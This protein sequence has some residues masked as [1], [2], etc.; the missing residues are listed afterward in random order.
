MLLAFDAGHHEQIALPA[1]LALVLDARRP[2]IV[3]QL[4]MDE[5]AGVVFFWRDI[6]KTPFDGD[7]VIAVTLQRPQITDGRAVAMNEAVGDAPRF[8]RVGVVSHA[9]GQAVEI[10][11]VEEFDAVGRR[12]DIL[13]G[14]NF[15]QRQREAK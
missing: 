5:H 12:D 13:R 15:C 3:G 1:G 4:H 14:G 7:D 6:K 10:R 2:D 11:A 8:H 9:K